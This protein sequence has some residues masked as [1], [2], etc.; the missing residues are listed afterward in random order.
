MCTQLLKGLKENKVYDEVKYLMR[1]SFKGQ[2]GQI[3]YD[4]LEIA[5]LFRLKNP[6]ME[7]EELLHNVLVNSTITLPSE[8]EVFE[9]MKDA[10][11][12]LHT[13]HV[14][15]LEDDRAVFRF[16]ENVTSEVRMRQLIRQR[17]IGQE[18]KDVDERIID[19]LCK[20]AMRT[21]MKPDDTFNE[22][23]NHTAGRCEY[24]EVEDLIVDLYKIVKNSNYED[25]LGKYDRNSQERQEE[26]KKIVNELQDEI[27]EYINLM[28]KERNQIMF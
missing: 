15:K 23:L 22:I 14:E 25:L 7:L 8:Q 10:V 18:L 1:E 13:R 24:E 19:I 2:Q 3:G 5:I 16:I 4:F 28:I 12:G 11:Q 6:E 9:F 17:V 27:K 21:I 26:K 20:V